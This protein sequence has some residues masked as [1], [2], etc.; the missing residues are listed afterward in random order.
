MGSATTI[1]TAYR[2]EERVEKPFQHGW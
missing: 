1:S 2:S